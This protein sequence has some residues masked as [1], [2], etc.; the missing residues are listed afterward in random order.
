MMSPDITLATERKEKENVG[1]SSNETS[2]VSHSGIYGKT[3]FY[4]IT[5]EYFNPFLK[6]A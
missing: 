3:T 6:K 2:A 5:A 1:S 4:H